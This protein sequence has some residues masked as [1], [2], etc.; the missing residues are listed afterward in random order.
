MFRLV[1]I[2]KLLRPHLNLIGNQQQASS[3]PGT[4]FRRAQNKRETLSRRLQRFCLPSTATILGSLICLLS[5]A[6]FQEATPALIARGTIYHDA[7]ANR[8]WDDGE[9][10]LPGIA[11][12]NGRQI[13]RTNDQGR[14]EIPVDEN[15]AAIFLIKPRGWRTPFSDD[16]LPQFYYI[17][18]PNGSPKS[19]YPGV[20]PTGSLPVTINFPLYPQDEPDS[21]QIVLFGDTQAR[22]QREIDYIGNDVVTELIGTKASFGI[23]LGDIVFDDLSLFE[24][25]NQTVAQLQIPWYNVIGNHDLNTDA[26][27]RRYVNE[28]YEDVYGPSYYSYDFGRVHF[29]VLDNCD[30]AIATEKEPARFV[31]NF[32]PDQ[33]EFLTNDLALVPESQLVVLMMHIPIMQAAD[34]EQ[35]FRL[36]ENRPLCISISGHTHTHEHHF[37]SAQQGWR[38]E[39]P[40]HHMV[41]VTVCGSWWSGQLDERGIPH[42]LMTDG[43][44]NGHSILTFDGDQYRLDYKAASRSADYQMQI[45][46][47]GPLVANKTAEARILANIF[48]GSE[49]SQV[50]FQIDQAGDWLEMHRTLEADPLYRKIYERE[51]LITPKIEPALNKPAISTHLWQAKL[52]ADLSAGT[53]LLTVRTVD[54][55]GRQYLARHF[56][57]IQ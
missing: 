39:K 36:I 51:L 3:R 41:N 46:T 26:T 18:K 11:V 23:T 4:S 33:I 21:F 56:I 20:K 22:N 43:G 27:Q 34:R 16:Q 19:R 7:N 38:G 13:V 40:H 5:A 10:L 28:T 42:S 48:N 37:L 29:V 2:K 12:S 25:H 15:D 47:E 54:M 9:K 6:A 30:W 24:S 50:H 49:R 14:Y 35:V 53:H 8:Q 57:T 44:P 17:H 32:G 52:P 31:P 55:D 1:S 45:S